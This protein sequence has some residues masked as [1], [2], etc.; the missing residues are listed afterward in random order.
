MIYANNSQIW[1]PS[2][3]LELLLLCFL[4][5]MNFHLFFSSSSYFSFTEKNSLLN[6]DSQL[7]S[8]D[9]QSITSWPSAKIIVT[10][11]SNLQNTWKTMGYKNQFQIMSFWYNHHELRMLSRSL[12][13]SESVWKLLHLDFALISFNWHYILRSRAKHFWSYWPGWRL[14]SLLHYITMAPFHFFRNSKKSAFPHDIL[15]FPPVQ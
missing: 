15:T 7:P 9:L 2:L 8:I 6:D 10:I 4:L 5:R 11:F 13:E 3:V 1:F 14:D 12:S